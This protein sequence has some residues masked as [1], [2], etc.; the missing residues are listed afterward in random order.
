MEPKKEYSQHEDNGKKITR[1][2]YDDPETK[3]HVVEIKIEGS[4]EEPD[5]KPQPCVSLFRLFAARTCSAA[6]PY[7]QTYAKC[8]MTM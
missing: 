4:E 7:R 2:R 5:K 6:H 1:S 8:R 3:T